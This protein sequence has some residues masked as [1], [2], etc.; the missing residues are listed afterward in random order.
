[1][2][3]SSS[4]KSQHI[5]DYLIYEMDEGKP[6]YYRGYKTVLKGEKTPEE[7][8]GSSYF[9]STLIELIKDYLKIQLGKKYFILASELGLLFKKKS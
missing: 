5:P 3:A 9:Q 8:M 1:M 2:T 6:I 7:I 4:K